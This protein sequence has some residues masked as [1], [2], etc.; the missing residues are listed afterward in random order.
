MDAVRVCVCIYV[1]FAFPVQFLPARNSLCSTI[2]SIKCFKISESVN[3]SVVL[4]I[5]HAAVTVS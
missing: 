1:G 3:D 4:N 5:R 2:E